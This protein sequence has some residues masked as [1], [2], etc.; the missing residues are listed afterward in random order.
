MRC[1]NCKEDKSPSTTERWNLIV[2]IFRKLPGYA[3]VALAFAMLCQAGRSQSTSG[4]RDV[5]FWREPGVQVEYSSFLFRSKKAEEQVPCPVNHGPDATDALG[6]CQWQSNQFQHLPQWV[7]VHFA[8]ERRID[9]VVLHA[10]SLATSPVEFSGQYLGHDGTFHTLLHVQGGHFDPQTLTYTAHFA[11]VVTDNFRLVI[12]RT[13]AKVTPQSWLA[14]LGQ[15]QVFGT[16]AAA[17]PAAVSSSNSAVVAVAPHARL[18][19]TA[20]VPQVEELSGRVEI[21]TPWYRLVLD[22]L[23]PRV[24]SLALDSLGKGELG[25]NLLQEAGAYPI[26]DRPFENALPLGDGALTRIGNLFWYEPVEIAPGV[27]EQVSIRAGARG[28]DLSINAVANHTVKMRGGLFRFQFAANQTPTTFICHPSKL[29]N[30]VDVPTYLSRPRFWNGIHHADG[31]RGGVLS[32]AVFA[33]PGHVVCGGHYA[34]PAEERRRPERDRAAAL[35]HNATLHGAEPRTAAGTARP[36]SAACAIS[37]ILA[38]YDAVAV[39]HRHREQQR[40]EHQLRAGDAVLRGAGDVGPTPRRRHFANGAGGRFGGSVFQGR[41]WVHDAQPEC[42]LAG[43]EVVAGDAS[44]P[45]DFRR[46]T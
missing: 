21:R 9:K 34:A 2:G 28:F 37:E 44:L 5:A 43:V 32:K 17:S 27:Y 14:E 12:E 10:A 18:A 40:D 39:G 22:R 23:Q 1:S 20:F 38:G 13:T 42:V 36:R 15:M 25:V 16:E 33:V 4:Y 45:G 30:Y 19:P 29:M 7:W 3:A 31:G 46:G 35:A 41:A 26:L 24:L 11:P 6:P 8:G